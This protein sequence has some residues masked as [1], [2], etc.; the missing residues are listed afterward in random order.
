LHA[1]GLRIVGEPSANDLTPVA[2]LPA[3]V[4]HI[5]EFLAA[6]RHEI[7]SITLL[8]V[9]ADC[10]FPDS[11]DAAAF[12]TALGGLALPR[13]DPV[14]YGVRDR[15]VG[16]R[17]KKSLLGRAYDRTFRDERT[18]GGRSGTLVRIEAIW[19]PRG[20]RD[21]IGLGSDELRDE[22]ARRFRPFLSLPP[23]TVMG[24]DDA[25]RDIGER[26][27]AG[28]LRRV[29][30]ERLLGSMIL[31]PPKPKARLCYL[32]ERELRDAGYVAVTRPVVRRD[33]SVS[34]VF[35]AC[36]DSECWGTQR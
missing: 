34:D 20:L 13:A 1:N 28:E 3:A 7:R 6:A 29:K 26:Y 19:R 31:E 11:G 36:V 24:L 2:D 25:L 22:F 32:R 14:R 27:T 15:S 33:V 17:G 35:Q 23:L 9:G 4:A 12:L 30:A 5:D 10:W 16:W 8:D 18:R 21:V